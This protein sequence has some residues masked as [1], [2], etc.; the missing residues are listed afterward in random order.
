MWGVALVKKH[1]DK[2]TK[3]VGVGALIRLNA[4]QQDSLDAARGKRSRA[5]FIFDALA[6]QLGW[7]G[8]LA[9]QA[10][11][12]RPRNPLPSTVFD[13]AEFLRTLDEYARWCQA[14]DWV[15]RRR[16]PPPSDPTMLA[17][18][19]EGRPARDGKMLLDHQRKGIS[20]LL[21]RNMRAFLCDEMGL[22]KTR[23]AIC[24][25]RASGARRVLVVCPA[26]ARRVWLEEIENSSG[27]HDRDV[28]VCTIDSALWSEDLPDEG[29]VIASYEVVAATEESW[30]SATQAEESVLVAAIDEVDP[31]W[32]DRQRFRTA[33]G[34]NEDTVWHAKLLRIPVSE[35]I[36]RRL[37]GLDLAAV[38]RGS[39]GEID[40]QRLHRFVNL[41]RRI[42]AEPLRRLNRWEPDVILADEAHRIKNPTAAR[43]HAMKHL[44]RVQRRGVVLLTGTPLRNRP[45]EAKTLIEY[46]APGSVKQT[47]LSKGRGAHRDR[48]RVAL[49]KLMLRR[50]KTDCLD[51]PE[52]IQQTYEYHIKDDLKSGTKYLAGYLESVDLMNESKEKLKLAIKSGAPSDVIFDLLKS[53]ST[54]VTYARQQ[55]GIL[56]VNQTSLAADIVDVVDAEGCC[57]CF[58][59]HH[60]VSDRLGEILHG[61]RLKVRVIDGR[62]KPQVRDAAAADFQAGRLDV[63][64]C[65]IHSA[66]EAITLTRAQTTFF[67]ELDWVPAALQ[68]AEDR[69]HRIGQI[70]PH[71][72]RIIR[73]VAGL[74]GEN[75]DDQIMEILNRKIDLINETLKEKSPMIPD[76]EDPLLALSIALL[77]DVGPIKVKKSTRAKDAKRKH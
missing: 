77:E 17:G 11:R 15:Q 12:G 36:A 13:S 37:A 70:A 20:F 9:I 16:Q 3:A 45:R 52:K 75:L 64:I 30:H 35:A 21:R 18:W 59:V 46:V 19:K 53:M 42:S 58:T 48:L 6:A 76:S 29:W 41:L 38:F 32:C 2:K 5:A 24:A 28:P 7:E 69:A 23:Q 39:D 63:L 33:P 50:L 43:S 8:D 61:R 34:S 40:Q 4:A 57:L 27:L 22:G 72:Y 1:Q 49:S 25:A 14:Q 68:Q 66:G 71:G 74:D 44:M 54:Y 65:G 31:D 26:S 62:S 56:K 10:P 47:A 73:C 60:A 67:V 51:L 55:L